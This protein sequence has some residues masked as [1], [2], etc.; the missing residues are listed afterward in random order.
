M[1]LPIKSPSSIWGSLYLLRAGTELYLAYFVIKRKQTQKKAPKKLFIIL[2]SSMTREQGILGTRMHIPITAQQS[3]VAHHQASQILWRTKISY[4]AS[5]HE[6][7]SQTNGTTCR[8]TVP[9]RPAPSPPSEST[10][11][12]TSILPP[13]SPSGGG[14]LPSLKSGGQIINFICSQPSS[15]GW[16]YPFHSHNCI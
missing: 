1:P 4:L 6:P 7:S 8:L 9:C 10:D 12:I 2:L 3:T 14:Y 15:H 13:E 16:K 11:L 5:K